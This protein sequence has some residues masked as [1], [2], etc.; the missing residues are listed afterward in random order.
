[1][2]RESR[3]DLTLKRRPHDK[4]DH[5]QIKEQHCGLTDTMRGVAFCA[6]EESA[7]DQ[8]YAH[9]QLGYEIEIRLEA[10]ARAKKPVHDG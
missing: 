10:G 8:R 6:C 4:S 2:F 9:G 3:Q 7:A 5:D 1:M